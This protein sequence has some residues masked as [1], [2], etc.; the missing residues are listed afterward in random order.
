MVWF[1]YA[2]CCA[3]CLATADALCKK[4]LKDTETIVVAWVRLG[5]ALPFLLITILPLEIPSLD[6]TFWQT[7]VFLLPLEIAAIL[8]YIKAIKV[9]P[10]SL[11]I[12]FQALTPVFLILT[13]FLILGETL[14][15]SGCAGILL[16]AGGV[17]VLNLQE[18][19]KSF[20]APFQNILK[21]KGVL[22]MIGVAFIY[23]LTSNLGKL[24]LLHSNPLFFGAFYTLVLTI[25]LTPFACFSIVKKPFNL[26]PKLKTFLLI[27]L[28]YALMI[29]FHYQAIARVEVAY[30]IS[31][32]RMSLFF[33]VLY[34]GLL[35]RETNI[36]ER[37]AGSVI[38]IVGVALITLI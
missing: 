19:E 3:F 36:S 34:G 30:M 17:Y 1:L 27:G 22:I 7:L 33:S 2:L 14:D 37:A 9:S 10:L 25:I 18:G 5:F 29:V 31:V 11:A 12:P 6:K 4:V 21:E 20:L 32:K 35:F 26:R 16:I 24:A 8:L 15:K 23:S 38:M 28:F 13:S